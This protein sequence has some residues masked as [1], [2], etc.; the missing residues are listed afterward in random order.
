MAVVRFPPAGHLVTTWS[1]DFLGVLLPLVLLGAYAWPLARTWRS[2]RRWPVWRVACYAGGLL[3]LTCALDGSPAAYRATIPWLGG[4]S[5]GLV[6]AVVPLGLALGD[7]VTLWEQA[8]GRSTRWLRGRL[9]RAVMF[10]LLASALSAVLLT[11]AFTGPWYAAARAHETPWA[12]LQ[13]A[14]LAVGLLVNLPLLT[15]DL[16]PA[17]CGPGLRTL[18]AFVDGLFDAVP[19]IVVMTTVEK[20]TGGALLSVA[21]AVGIPMIFAVLLTW[22]RSDERD[23]RVADARLDAAEA[24]ALAEGTGDGPAPL[25]WQSDPQLSRRFQRPPQSPDA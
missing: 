22:V 25:W 16:L 19:G 3:V 14:V 24:A 7:P 15:E 20:Y 12:L 10:P 23:A 1:P 18:L 13:L 2:G 6:A 11:V 9:A 5:V 4:L 21:E 8:T 17:W